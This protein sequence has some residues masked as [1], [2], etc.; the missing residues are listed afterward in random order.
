LHSRCLVVSALFPYTTL[1]RSLLGRCERT[2]LARRKWTE[3]GTVDYQIAFAVEINQGQR[4]AGCPSDEDDIALSQ[5]GAE[6][7]GRRH[8]DEHERVARRAGVVAHP[9][10][11]LALAVRPRR[12]ARDVGAHTLK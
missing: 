11:E 4:P 1:F 6:G 3:I 2:A 9:V 8:V 12:P 10:F 7:R 5:V